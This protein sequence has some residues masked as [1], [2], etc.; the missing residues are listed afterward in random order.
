MAQSWPW[1]SQI[2][3]KK[4][5]KNIE[6]VPLGTLPQEV[7]MLLANNQVQGFFLSTLL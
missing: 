1:G 4:K 6:K 7:V 2:A 5:K 3:V